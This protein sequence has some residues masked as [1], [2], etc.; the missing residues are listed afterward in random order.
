M[1]R[2]LRIIFE[3]I[4]A[5]GPADPPEPPYR[6]DGPLYAVMPKIVRHLSRWSQL[7]GGTPYYIPAHFPVIF[8]DLDVSGGRPPDETYKGFSI[9]YPVRERMQ[10]RFSGAVEPPDLQYIRANPAPPC[11]PAPGEMDPVRDIAMVADMREI[12]P[13]RQWLRRGTLD[14]GPNADYAVAAQVFVPSGCIG[15]HGEFKKKNPAVV[16]FRETRTPPITVTKDLL[17]QIVVSVRTDTVDIDMYSLDTGLPLD[18]LSFILKDGLRNVIRVAN[19][20]PMNVRYVIDNLPDPDNAPDLPTPRPNG[21]NVSGD[22]DIGDIDFEAVY[23]VLAGQD[24]GGDLPIP[25]IPIVF[26][27]RNCNGAKV[28]GPEPLETAKK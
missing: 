27:A 4:I 23:D 24:G 28:A 1:T 12:W 10:F 11:A 5:I 18:P 15:S 7:H 3:G 8:T 25:W 20:D 17:P 26:G 9:W 22:S 6:H 21:H 16:E 14:S 2:E 19:G 13:D